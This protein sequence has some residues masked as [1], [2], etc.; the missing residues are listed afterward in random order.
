MKTHGRGSGQAMLVAAIA[1]LALLLLVGVVFAQPGSPETTITLSSAPSPPTAIKPGEAQTFQWQI[2]ATS[3][4]VSVSY[5][6]SNIDTG[7]PIESQVYPGSTGLN[8]T[9]SYVL[10]TTYVLPFGRLFE[11]YRVRIEYYSLESGNE[12]NAEAIFWVTQ[13][14]GSLKVVKFNDRDGDGLRDPG[15]EG[16]AGVL[17]TLRI[18]GQNLS[19]LTDANGEILW[20]NVPVGTYQVTETVPAG[21]VNTTPIVQ[22]PT[23]TANATT[24]ILF[25]NR[26]IPG[27]LEA[28]VWV[29]LNGDRIRDP[30]EPPYPGATVAFVSPC[31]DDGSGVTGAGGLVV[32]PNR[33]VGNY[34]VTLTVPPGYGATT[35]ASVPATVVSNTT[36]HVEFGIQLDTACVEGQ[37]ISDTH[38]G[39]P[40]WTIRAQLVGGTGPI[41]T[42][43][44]G[45][46]GFFRMDRLP[47]GTYRFWEEPQIG[48]FPV[49]PSEFQVPVLQPGAQC[50]HIRFKNRAATPVP[51]LARRAYAPVL[52]KRA[53]SSGTVEPGTPT[54]TPQGAGCVVAT[55]VDALAVGL[56]GW[57]I[58]VQP[59]GG[60]PVRSGVT[61]GLGAIQFD[62][63]P[64]GPAVVF[65]EAQVG[66]VPVTPGVVNVMVTP[67]GQCAIVQFTNR[68]A[69]PTPTYTNTPTSTPTSTPTPTPTATPTRP[70]YGDPLAHTAAD[71]S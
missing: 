10:P 15:D 9:R 5:E 3:T 13:D 56:P 16:V 20:T 47:L 6:V 44:T 34:T 58:R 28:L 7:Q 62:G 41:Y 18:Q 32:W 55:K 42:A 8:L 31:G 50:L 29:D 46:G 27:A 38:V 57:T 59:Q 1:G 49:T 51:P 65:E 33:C 43:V 21:T 66:W 54:P 2:I 30:G 39:L 22:Q 70:P 64:G 11:R 26:V 69:T 61:N 48:W 36:T 23:V 45:P 4:P 35:P 52:Y 67:G 40:G 19:R 25:G 60:G 71:H 68:Q 12:A 14:T 24:T 63:V 37:K 17:F 53:S